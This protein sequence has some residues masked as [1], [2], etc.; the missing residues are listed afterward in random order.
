MSGSRPTIQRVSVVLA[1]PVASVG[2]HAHAAATRSVIAFSGYSHTVKT[3]KCQPW[4][5]AMIPVAAGFSLP[6]LAA[7]G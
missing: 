7:A 6:N 2:H 5:T 4:A 3:A 1:V